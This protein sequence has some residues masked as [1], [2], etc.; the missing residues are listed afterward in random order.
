MTARRFAE[1]VLLAALIALGLVLGAERLLSQADPEVL[2]QAAAWFTLHLFIVFAVFAWRRPHDRVLLLFAVCALSWSLRLALGQHASS[3]II[4]MAGAA[5]FEHIFAAAAFVVLLRIALLRQR[6]F[7]RAV[8]GYV[9]AVVAALAVATAVDSDRGVGLIVTSSANVVRV[10]SVLVVLAAAR[11]LAHTAN[12]ELAVLLL[13]ALVMIFLSIEPLWAYVAPDV[14][15]KALRTLCF[16][17][18]VTILL[19]YRLSSALGTAEVLSADLQ[20]V[21][22]EKTRELEQRF[23]QVSVLQREQVRREERERIMRDMHDGVGGQLIAVLANLRRNL[24]VDRELL[25]RHLRAALLDLR[26]MVDSLDN[27]EGSLQA[28]LAMFR[29]RVQP[30]IDAAGWRSEWRLEGVPD[31][32]GYSSR[33]LLD[34]TRILQEA[35]SNALAHSGGQNLIVDVTNSADEVCFEVRDDGVAAPHA[36]AGQGISNMHV[37]AERIGARLSWHAEAGGTS[38]VLCVPG[39]RHRACTD[40]RAP[41]P[42]QAHASDQRVPERGTA[43]V[44]SPSSS[45]SR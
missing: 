17:P 38:V 42:S 3:S 45:G 19:I 36:E 30:L 23:E 20:R 2:V 32:E 31:A 14:D 41:L 28:A 25:L 13:A 22:A 24:S 27:E 16:G 26:H 9:G 44:Q 37:R 4:A 6:W 11:T 18:T 40:A 33:T 1:G 21:V 15:A 5:A 43:P 10:T 34:I 39:V 7:E 8:V 35:V 12:R 29:S